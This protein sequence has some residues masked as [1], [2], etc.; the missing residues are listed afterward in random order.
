MELYL[1]FGHG[2]MALTRDLLRNWG[3]GKVILSPRDLDLS[4]IQRVSADV[5][6]LSGEVLL[7]PQCYARDA[8]HHR[9]CGH[10]YFAIFQSNSSSNLLLGSGAAELL[11]SLMRLV[12]TLGVQRYILPGVLGDPVDDLWFA[13]QERFISEAPNHFGERGLLATIALSANSMLDEAQIE[14]V[15]DRASQWPVDGFYIV[16][17]SPSGYLV[18]NPIWVSNLLILTSGLKLLGKEVVV[19][20]CNHQSICLAAA[21]VDAICSGTWLNV[22]SFS[23]NKFYMPGADEVSRRTTWYYCAIALSEYTLPFMDIAK[24][25]NILLEMRCNPELGSN[26]ANILF[27]GPDPSSIRWGEGEAFRHYLTCLHSQVAAALKPSY[28]DTLTSY[29]Q[30]LANA[31]RVIRRFHGLGISGLARDFRYCIDVNR[32][33]LII[34]DQARGHQ[35]RRNW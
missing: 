33:A 7:D 24:R 15:I 3:G 19:G 29:D 27:A 32:S 21:N 5:L 2:M 11:S 18:D 16:A 13:L 34:F 8:D 26:Y 1:Q 30:L 22:R 9:L 28:Q 23:P 25:Q 6:S 12:S 35:L 20:Y 4:Q 14:A 17:Q 10:E 31:E